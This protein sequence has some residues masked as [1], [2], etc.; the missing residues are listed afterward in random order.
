MIPFPAVFALGNAQVHVGSS[1][2][3]NEVS[4]IEALIDDPFGS[5]SIL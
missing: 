4:Y 5:R 1:N 3:S 2:S